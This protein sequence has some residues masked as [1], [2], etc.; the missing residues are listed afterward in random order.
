MF[1]FDLDKV[2]WAEPETEMSTV[3]ASKH[4]IPEIREAKNKEIQKLESFGAFKP[5]QLSSLSEDQK[6]KVI[7]T[8]WTVVHKPHANEGKGDLV[9]VEGEVE[10][11]PSWNGRQPS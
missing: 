11:W 8:T 3:P 9:T 5:I 1:L 10:L 2:A 6:A 7:A 4:G